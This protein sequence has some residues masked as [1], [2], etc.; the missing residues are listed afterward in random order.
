[1]HP[2]WQHYRREQTTTY[3]ER[4]RLVE[5]CQFY[6][7]VASCQQVATNVPDSSSGNKSVKIRFAATCH[8]QICYNLLKQLLARLWIISFDNQLAV[9]L[10]KT[11]N[12]LVVNN[13]HVSL[14]ALQLASLLAICTSLAVCMTAL[15]P[16]RQ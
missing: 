9:S 14:V 11:C 5:S 2:V 6:Q 10:L 1:M 3:T 13:L 12:R 16:C 8:L 15:N 7:L 4:D